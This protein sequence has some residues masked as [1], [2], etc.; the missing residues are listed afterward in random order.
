[1]RFYRIL[2]AAPS[3]FAHLFD[4]KQNKCFKLVTYDIIL[5]KEVL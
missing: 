3:F 5:K 1:M 4:F 2:V